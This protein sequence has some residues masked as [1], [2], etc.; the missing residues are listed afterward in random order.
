[1]S[2]LALISVRCQVSISIV[3]LVL[4]VGTGCVNYPT[5]KPLTSSGLPVQFD[6]YDDAFQY[7]GEFNFSND[8][9]ENWSIA[10]L[11]TDSQSDRMHFI[12]AGYFIVVTVHYYDQAGNDTLR[13]PRGNGGIYVLQ[14]LR[15]RKVRLVGIMAGS[16]Y[17]WN[18]WDTSEQSHPVIFSSWHDN[19]NDVFDPHVWN[20]GFFDAPIY[21]Y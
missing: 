16:L 4:F 10:K 13:S 2:C 21:L 11:E 15:G 1:M 5:G 20:G 19:A 18:P 17:Y 14:E 6:G 7:I 8:P 9:S 12:D 3:F